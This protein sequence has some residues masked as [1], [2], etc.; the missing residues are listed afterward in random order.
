[1]A[2]KKVNIFDN[3]ADFFELKRSM[4]YPSLSHINTTKETYFATRY[5]L[6]N[7][8]DIVLYDTEDDT[9][10]YVFWTE[11]NATSYPASRYTPIG[12]V[13]IPE[14]FNGM[15][16]RM[17]SL[18]YMSCDTPN[19]GTL[20][21]DYIQFG[22]VIDDND[23]WVYYDI[24][25]LV[26]Y[27]V[28]SRYQ[29]CVLPSG[30]LHGNTADWGYLPSDK[31]KGKG[32]ANYTDEKTA[33]VQW[34][35]ET[36]F[37]PS[38]YTNRWELYAQFGVGASQDSMLSDLNGKQNTSIILNLC[39]RQED[40]RTDSQI[41][42]N[43]KLNHYPA[44][45]CCYRYSTADTEQGDWY[46]PSAG[47]LVFLM[48]RWKVIQNALKAVQKVNSTVAVPLYEYD[49]Y[50]SSSEYSQ[51]SAYIL[52]SGNGNLFNGSKGNNILVRAFC[53]LPRI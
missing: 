49:G 10:L 16:A 35:D 15:Q 19:V 17:I 34:A 30:N 42:R 39:T 7:V 9:R 33:W 22:G 28:N 21:N 52:N 45:M 44:A 23:N 38:P 40:W 31:F 43:A 27:G 5:R 11:Y 26:N 3:E 47:E 4:P 20:N 8:G 12:V 46:L 53:L 24:P 13:V 29:K 36:R 6:A 37:F 2:F 18:V 1:M 51:Y 41:E 48:A 14:R 32:F 50:W 25:D